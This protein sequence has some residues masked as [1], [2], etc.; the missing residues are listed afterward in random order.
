MEQVLQHIKEHGLNWGIVTNRLEH[1]TRP[2]LLTLNLPS[3]PAVIVCGDTLARCKPHPDPVIHAYTLL[4]KS[5]QQCLFIGDSI[6][7]IQAGKAAGVKTVAALYGYIEV[8]DNPL[9]WQADY[10]IKKPEELL[11]IFTY[12]QPT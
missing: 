10:N 3:Q 9:D 6:R 5:P 1:L 7:D 8:H 4:K 12:T 2:L 11:E